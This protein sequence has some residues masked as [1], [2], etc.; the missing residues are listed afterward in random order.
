MVM[1]QMISERFIYI[2][3]IFSWKALD[4]L[5]ISTYVRDTTKTDCGTVP[6]Y[7]AVLLFLLLRTETAVARTPICFMEWG[8]ATRKK[9]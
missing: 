4:I 9:M 7:F 5:R 3:V 6:S 2:T 8:C 1:M